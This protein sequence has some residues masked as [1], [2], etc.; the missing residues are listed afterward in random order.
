MAPAGRFLP[1]PSKLTVCPSSVRRP[2]LA[3]G[4]RVIVASALPGRGGLC[5][6]SVISFDH[7]A[8]Q[9]STPGLGE[10]TS[11]RPGRGGLCRA[12]FCG[13]VR[14]SVVRRPAVRPS[15][16]ARLATVPLEGEGW[17]RV[18]SLG[19]P[20]LVWS[21]RPSRG[22][23]A[24]GLTLRSSSFVLSDHRGGGCDTGTLTVRLSEVAQRRVGFIAI[25][26]WAVAEA[27]KPNTLW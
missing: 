25:P 12:T 17:R 3:V 5:V 21:V 14:P 18:A 4:W 9:S 7:C 24:S 2:S 8:G 1:S 19:R 6:C 23:G 16:A 27:P 26:S 20:S 22:S 15:E 10:F 13:G 11:A